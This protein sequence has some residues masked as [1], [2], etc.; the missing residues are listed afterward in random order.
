MLT[1]ETMA[2]RHVSTPSMLRAVAV[3][4]VVGEVVASAGDAEAEVVAL[5]CSGLWAN[6][7]RSIL[8]DV[9]V[10]ELSTDEWA[11]RLLGTWWQEGRV[12][13]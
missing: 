10:I 11:W 2:R 4:P 12:L 8:R 7:R 1:P 13:G 6:V 9:R 3:M 5:R